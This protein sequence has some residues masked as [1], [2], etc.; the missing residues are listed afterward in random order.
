ML[1]SQYFILPVL[2]LR[3]A[4][5]VSKEALHTLAQLFIEI[6]DPKISPHIIH[7]QLYTYNDML[8]SILV[9]KLGWLGA[10]FKTPLEHLMGRLSFI[11]GY[12]HSDH[13]SHMMITKDLQSGDL[14]IN[15]KSQAETSTILK[16]VS[17][18]L[19]RNSLKTGFIPLFPFINISEPGR[20]F[21]SGG[22]FP[23][24]ERPN[25]Y[26]CDRLGRPAGLQRV[27]L[28]DSSSFPTLPATTITLTVMANAYR[29]GSNA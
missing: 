25:K 23:M 29:I 8:R 24:R 15:G 18:K 27:H 13:S 26:E 1:D 4:P 10:A 5:S 17:R 16:K 9:S 21:H 14:V 11:Q 7:L 22:T 28:I 3:H 6:S 20:G 2:A 12:L 19:L